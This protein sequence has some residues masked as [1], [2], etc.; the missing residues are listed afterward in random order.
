L[1]ALLYFTNGQNHTLPYSF[2]FLIVTLL[3]IS[4]FC[5]FINELT[6]KQH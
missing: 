3:A 2:G 5:V 6:A 4:N 1:L